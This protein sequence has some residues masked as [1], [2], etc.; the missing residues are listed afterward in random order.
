[1]IVHSKAHVALPWKM[2]Y[3]LRVLTPA[4][5][6]HGQKKY[7]IHPAL[8]TPMSVIIIIIAHDVYDDFAFFP[9][10]MTTKWSLARYCC[11]CWHDKHGHA[12]LK[13]ILP[14]AAPTVNGFPLFLDTCFSG[15]KKKGQKKH[16]HEDSLH[17][18]P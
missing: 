8:V 10:L 6:T 15:E 14:V 18:R 11:C 5:F 16:T 2:T 1:M 3:R 17:S 13:N 7:M 9:F 4:G 12:W